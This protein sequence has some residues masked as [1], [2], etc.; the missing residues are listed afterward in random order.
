MSREHIETAVD[1]VHLGR[2]VMDGWDIG[3]DRGELKYEPSSSTR[4]REEDGTKQKDHATKSSIPMT[5]V[6]FATKQQCM[7]AR[8]ALRSIW[9]DSPNQVDTFHGSTSPEQRLNLLDKFKKGLIRVLCCTKAF[10]LGCDIPDIEY[11]IIYNYVDS[12]VDL[13]QKGGRAARGRGEEV[14]GFASY[15]PEPHSLHEEKVQVPPAPSSKV[16]FPI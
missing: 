10:G 6:F 9:L 1:A 12:M 15:I 4:G 8:D 7:D 13:W 14:R 3:P 5:V 2:R 11:S 16:S